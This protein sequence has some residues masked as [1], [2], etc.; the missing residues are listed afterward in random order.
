MSNQTKS[1]KPTILLVGAGAVGS[2]IAT[3]LAP[4][5]ENFYVLDQGEVLANINENGVVAY[6]QFNREEAE[7]ARV[8]T[9]SS[10]DEAPKPDFILLCVKNYSLDGLAKAIQ[11]KFGDDPVVV[12]LQNGVENQS[13]L[14]K[15]FSK[16]I[17]GIITYNAWLDEPGVAGYQKRG[18]VVIGTLDNQLQTELKQLQAI[19]QLGVETV[20]TDHFMDGAL[21]KMIINL[22]NSF[23]TLIGFSVRPVENRDLFQTI[24]GRLTY[25][26]VQIVK[27][28]G[29][30]ECKLGGMPPW[31]LIAANARL[32]HFLTRPLFEKNVHKM[33]ISSMEQ[34]VIQN[35]RGNNELES[36]NG[37]LLNLAHEHGIS[38]P[39]NETIYALCQREFSQK[40][41]TPMSIEAVWEAI[42]AYKKGIPVAMEVS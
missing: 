34:D 7:K 8:K 15:Y 23:T 40:E 18:P 2:T 17:Y 3:W 6:Q 20:I 5:H 30:K 42:K 35:H 36:I 11:N 19:F 25:E 9:I 4:H 37:Y 24:L 28:A 10:L 31:L 21:S 27:G 33:V 14:P 41:F 29:H 26:G 1:N 32:P 13:I 22:T 39:F 16:V 38:A 12:G